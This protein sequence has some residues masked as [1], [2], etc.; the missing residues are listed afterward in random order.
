MIHEAARALLGTYLVREKGGNVTYGTIR[1]LGL[2]LGLD[3]YLP[4]DLKTPKSQ[5]DSTQSSGLKYRRV[6]TARFHFCMVSHATFIS[7]QNVS[8][9]FSLLGICI[10][11]PCL[12]FFVCP[13]GASQKS[14]SFIIEPLSRFSNVFSVVVDTVFLVL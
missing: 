4:R 1:V 12:I 3:T 2:Y 7:M 9:Y 11:P 8:K 13:L 5:P 10:C 14:I 6:F